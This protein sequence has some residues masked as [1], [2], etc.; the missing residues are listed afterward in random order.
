MAFHQLS[1]MQNRLN[2][3][4]TKSTLLKTI[5][6]LAD[7]VSAK[8]SVSSKLLIDGTQNSL[9][10]LLQS[11]LDSVLERVVLSAACLLDLFSLGW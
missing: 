11:S 6:R 1:S 2:I 8:T 4:G 9:D 3:A 5:Q 10:G 7:Y